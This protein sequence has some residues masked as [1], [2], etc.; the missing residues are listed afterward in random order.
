MHNSFIQFYYKTKGDNF[1]L[2]LYNLA[3]KLTSCQ[4]NSNMYYFNFCKRYNFNNQ[5]LMQE[6]VRIGTK[7]KG[8]ITI[9]ELQNMTLNQYCILLNAIYANIEE[10]KQNDK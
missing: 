7:C 5:K 8:S 9:R 3:W 6:M 1:L 2:Q 10:D 4:S